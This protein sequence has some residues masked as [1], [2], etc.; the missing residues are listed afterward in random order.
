MRKEKFS[1]YE[2]VR[3]SGL[4]NML[5]INEV[6]LIAIKFGQ[7]LS[8]KDCFDIML[9]YDKYKKKYGSKKN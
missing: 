8:K 4:T 9:N 2:K 5:D 7:M 6:R 3:K 1:A